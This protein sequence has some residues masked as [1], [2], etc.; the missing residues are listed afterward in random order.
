[1]DK[2]LAKYA[3]PEADLSMPA[4]EQYANVLCIPAFDESP[5]FLEQMFSGNDEKNLLVILVINA[6]ADSSPSAIE[7]TRD[8]GAYLTSRA[9]AQKQLSETT[10][11]LSMDHS[12]DILLIN[13]C[14]PGHFLPVK[15]GVGLARKIACD[16][17]CRLISEGIVTTQWIHSSDADARLPPDYFQVMHQLDSTEDSA[18]IYPFMHLDHSASTVR[19]AQQLYDFS[20]EYYVAGLRF[21]GSPWA[22]HTI[23]ST[24]VI[25]AEKY[26]Q[27]R[28]FPKREAG[29]DFY[30]LNKLVKLGRTV[31]L[32]SE[33]VLLDSRLSDRVPF[34][35]GPGVRTILALKN[36]V[37]E[38][39][40]YHPDC[41][42]YLKT[43]QAI[44]A[45]LGP[46]LVKDPDQ[47]MD[48]INTRAR[49][50]GLNPELLQECL[51]TLGI[52]KAVIHAVRH[53]RETPVF[54]RHL[55]AWFDAFMTLK[56]IH[57]LRDNHFPSQPLSTIRDVADP[58]FAAFLEAYAPMP[59]AWNQ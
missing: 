24:L 52:H 32:K 58:D 53:G 10:D 13:R 4:G 34:G 6:S 47:L 9:T 49:V 55:Q 57:W 1:M 38:F 18:G 22:F 44:L 33:P 50:S 59:P 54:R 20:M 45:D 14:S 26:A 46:D 15:C 40:Y 41:F 48:L 11:W 39:M 8:I 27:V 43:W 17:A 28:G 19:L 25:H 5:T 42:L 30:L 2:Y 21:A 29:E 56:F 3:E 37:K 31:S 12:A 51:R 7:R 16:T 36:P 35:T 23:G